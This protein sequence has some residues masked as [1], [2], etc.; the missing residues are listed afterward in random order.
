[1]QSRGYLTFLIIL[2]YAFACGLV[3]SLL[4]KFGKSR[5]KTFCYIGGV[6]GGLLSLYFAWV[7]FL[8]ALMHRFTAINLGL[9][10][11]F[12][13]PLMMLDLIRSINETGWFSIKGGTPSGIFLWLL[14]AIEAVTILVV[15][16]LVGSGAI[17]D[18]MFC[19]KCGKWCDI[20]ETKHLKVPKEHGGSKASA[21]DPR[22][23]AALENAESAGQRPV[24]KAEL[25][26][27]GNCI[28][29]AGWRYKL[30]D[31]EIDKD[32]NEKDKTNTIPG[33]VMA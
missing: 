25:L 13:S 5:S 21:I 19:E 7:L 20:S 2:G 33:I 12:L 10:D 28:N 6:I 29:Y 31:T 4:L 14:W 32:G 22:M 9:P 17:D 24:L 16:T 18:E 8:Y 26:K 15:V 11:L 30:V 1:V 3:V 23:F 27:C